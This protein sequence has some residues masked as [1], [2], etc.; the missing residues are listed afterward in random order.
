[1]I[2]DQ[3]LPFLVHINPKIDNMVKLGFL[4]SNF[5]PNFV[6]LSR[7]YFLGYGCVAQL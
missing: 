6:S 5:F 3:L 1:M 7:K 2:M 4:L